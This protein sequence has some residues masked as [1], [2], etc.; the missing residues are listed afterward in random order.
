VISLETAKALGREISPTLR[1]R[2][3]D[4]IEGAVLQCDVEVLLPCS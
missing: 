3:D 4:V 1:S 2:A